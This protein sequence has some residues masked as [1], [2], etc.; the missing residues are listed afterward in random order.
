LGQ[1]KAGATVPSILSVIGTNK[2]RPT[3]QKTNDFTSAFQG[4]VDM[5]GIARYQEV[6]PGLFTIITFP[7]LFGVM[8]GDV[9]HGLILLAASL[10]LLGCWKFIK[11]PSETLQAALDQKWL[12]LLMS[13]FSIYCGFMYNE[14][15]SLPMGLFPSN[16]SYTNE[17]RPFIT[18]EH[19]TAFQVDPNYVYP[20]G[21]D[22]VRF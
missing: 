10:G 16:W 13:L 21:V 17:D 7:F 8:F 9:G 3:F 4:I 19:D 6:N 22:P 20:F 15:F 11:R 18:R 1:A 2:V 12:I 5:Y 14:F